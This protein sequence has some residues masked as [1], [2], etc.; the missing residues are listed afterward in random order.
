[1]ARYHWS[2][3]QTILGTQRRGLKM[4]GHILRIESTALYRGLGTTNYF[5]GGAAFFSLKNCLVFQNSMKK[6]VHDCIIKS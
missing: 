2:A 6:D 3:E 4:C 1:M 5:N